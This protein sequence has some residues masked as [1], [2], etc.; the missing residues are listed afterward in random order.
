MNDKVY[1]LKT[2]RGY[3]GDEDKVVNALADAFSEIMVEQ[4]EAKAK[5]MLIEAIHPKYRSRDVNIKFA[6]AFDGFLESADYRFNAETTES[7]IKQ[8]DEANMVRQRLENCWFTF[9]NL[10]KDLQISGDGRHLGDAQE[11]IRK[12]SLILGDDKEEV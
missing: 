4:I 3:H 2:T 6:K 5:E 8:R 1:I 12:I 10:Y 11:M 7:L 9:V